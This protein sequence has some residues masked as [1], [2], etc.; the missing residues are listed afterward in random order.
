MIAKIIVHAPTRKEAIS[1]MRGA[2]DEC[3][4]EG[5]KT[6]IP[7]LKEILANP[8]FIEGDIHTGFIDKLME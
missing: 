4:V 7:F 3:V 2:L 5:I 1:R 8:K 6:T